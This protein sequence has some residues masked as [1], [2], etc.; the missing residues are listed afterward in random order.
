MFSTVPIRSSI[1]STCLVGA[2]VQRPVERGHAGRHRR[3]GID[4]RGAD[5]AHRARRAVLLVVGVQDPEHV[6]GP[7]QP[8][9]G[10]VLDLGHLEHHREEVA[11]V[12]EVVVRIDVGQPEVV[13]VGEGGQ[14]G[15][16]RDQPHG[17]HVALASRSSMFLAAG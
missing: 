1:R 9:V 11:G 13:A 12:G 17:R 3:V 16:L 7:L 15:H 8:R 14:R 4:L 5:A 10:L 6:E 2:A